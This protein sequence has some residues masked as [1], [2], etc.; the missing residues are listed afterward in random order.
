MRR[1][2][3]DALLL[4]LAFALSATLAA[5]E[6]PPVTPGAARARL[7]A[8]NR[9]YAT[10]AV[11]PRRYRA[12]RPA[13]VDGQKPYAMVL[14]CADSRVPPEI[15][16]DE[17]LGAL[18][19]VR[20]AGNVASPDE[21]ASLE[22]AAGHLGTRYLLVL[23]HGSCGAVKASL[24]PADETPNLAGLLKEIRPAVAAAGATGGSPAVDE[25]V[26]ENVKLQCR[27][28]TGRSELL[29]KAVAEGKVAVAG[30][31]Y[32]LRSGTVAW[33]TP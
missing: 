17:G 28:V 2:R 29:R 18:F 21:L 7:E 19:V 10:S 20:V 1:P 13:L 32:D 6:Q 26:A 30:A 8:G 23:G 31:V 12:E 11:K 22:Y 33:V 15:L 27:N 5:G 4:C 3:A 25:V 14:A 16:F 9:R 24:S